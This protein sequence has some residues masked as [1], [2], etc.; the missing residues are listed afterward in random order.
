VAASGTVID[1]VGSNS[2]DP[3]LNERGWCQEGGTDRWHHL[4]DYMRYLEIFLDERA[5]RLSRKHFA[6]IRK[7]R[8]KYWTELDGRA[9]G[10]I[11]NLKKHIL[12]VF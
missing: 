8:K 6:G 4:L 3:M 5:C 1:S 2:F 10:R 11:G 12:G 7:H 9:A